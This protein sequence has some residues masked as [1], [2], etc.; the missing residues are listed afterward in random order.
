MKRTKEEWLKEWADL[1]DTPNPDTPEKAARRREMLHRRVAILNYVNG[2]GPEP[3]WPWK[4]QHP[5]TTEERANDRKEATER[6]FQDVQ[7]GIS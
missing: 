6:F 2:E 5:A 4:P 7:G 3:E 1:Q